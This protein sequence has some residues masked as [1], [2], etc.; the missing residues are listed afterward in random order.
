MDFIRDPGSLEDVY[1]RVDDWD[2]RGE[3]RTPGLLDEAHADFIADATMVVVASIGHGGV[4]CSPR[5]AT[6]GLI[7]RVED[8]RTIWVP[9]AA[10][11]RVHQTVRNLMEDPRLGLLF[12][13]PPREQVLRIEGMARVTADTEAL[14]AFAVLD[15]PVRS[16]MIVDVQ[17]VRMS[18]RGPVQRAGVWEDPAAAARLASG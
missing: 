16:V 4:T 15:P 18:G 11:G 9:D 1:G 2:R 7:A 6:P 5:G 17:A 3:S 12:M 10:G 14:A 13:A 8:A